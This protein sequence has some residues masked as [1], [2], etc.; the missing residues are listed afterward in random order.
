M[1]VTPLVPD[2]DVS[3]AEQITAY[4]SAVSHELRTPLSGIR[5]YAEMLLSGML[6]AVGERQRSGLGKISH[7]SHQVESMVEDLIVVLQTTTGTL[8]PFAEHVVVGALLERVRLAVTGF[9]VST[10]VDLHI[11]A[12]ERVSAIGLRADPR[13]LERALVNV[14]SNA[15][16]FSPQGGHVR[17]DVSADNGQLMIVVSDHGI[18]MSEP[19]LAA[20]FTPLSTASSARAHGLAGPGLGLAV[21]DAVIRGHEGLMWISSKAGAGTTVTITLPAPAADRHQV[22]ANRAAQQSSR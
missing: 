15:I 22:S 17:L 1:P 2:A 11:E 14:V 7:L 21:S 3:T 4:L 19:E 9:C 18:G 10:A 20:L 13:L 5:G 6:G 8:Q 16:K 12:A